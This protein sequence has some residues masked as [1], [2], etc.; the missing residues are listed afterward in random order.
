MF[1]NWP[2]YCEEVVSAVKAIYDTNS[3]P[4]FKCNINAKQ[5]TIL[6]ENE[7][8]SH[9]ERKYVLAGVPLF[10]ATINI[11]KHTLKDRLSILQVDN[12]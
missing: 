1:S 10:E 11:S 3:L 2:I 5:L 6:N 4:G 7:T 12:I 9:F 8:M